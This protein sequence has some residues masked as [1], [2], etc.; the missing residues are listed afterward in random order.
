MGRG[1][2]VGIIGGSGWYWG[3]GSGRGVGVIREVGGS[4][5]VDSCRRVG[6]RNIARRHAHADIAHY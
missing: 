3:V 6:I 1:R 2:V 5:G 4:G